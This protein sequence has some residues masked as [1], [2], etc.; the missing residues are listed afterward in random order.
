M[1][2]LHAPYR[3]NKDDASK[4]RIKRISESN[5]D[6]PELRMPEIESHEYVL[7]LFYEAGM[8]LNGANGAVPITW[9]ELRNYS[10]QSGAVL[11]PWESSMVMNMS[12]AYCSAYHDGQTPE[13]L[14]PWVDDSEESL[15][16][17]RASVAA[18][19]KAISAGAMPKSDPSKPRKKP[20]PA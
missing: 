9:T 8:V 7:G 2:W 5:P 19:L 4:S 14:P 15:E 20:K 1:G 11:T 12:R 6:A 18:K 3:L 10:D 13:A 17:M 16:A